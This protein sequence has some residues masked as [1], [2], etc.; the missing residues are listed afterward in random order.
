MP[1]ALKRRYAVHVSRDG[2]TIELFE[3]GAKAAA[4][5]LDAKSIRTSHNEG[6][7]IS[8]IILLARDRGWQ[9]L[10]VSGTAEF[11]DAVWL[12]ASKAGLS[13][14]HDPSSAARAALAKWDQERPANQIQQDGSARTREQGAQRG[15]ELAQ[16]FA[17][18]SA[19]ER[20]ADPRLRN[21]QLELMIGIRTAEK[22]LKR[23]IAEMPEVTQAL[24]AAVPRTAGAGNDVRRPFCQG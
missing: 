1:D 10:K 3:A 20:L 4:I 6:V 8:D 9:A 13:V 17:A 7:A 15:D 18:K 11:K 12:E 16:A 22:E 21:A 23:P 24:T 5:T 2:Q 14:Q 19:E